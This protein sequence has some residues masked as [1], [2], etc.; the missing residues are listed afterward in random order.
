MR[1]HDYLDYHAR[2][3]PQ[4]D[5]AVDA[6]QR[7]TYGEARERANRLANALIAADLR[8]GDRI[9]FLSKN[10]AD[11][12]L[13]FLG[14]SKA[15]VVPVP[16][17]YRLAGPELAYIIG[18]AGARLLLA[19]A[20]Y[21]GLL[22]EIRPELITVERY[23]A[24]D[25]PEAAGWEDFRSMVASGSAAEPERWIDEES[26]VY[27]MYTSGTTGRPKGAILTHRAV[28]A[29]M[30]QIEAVFP[31]T[32]GERFLVVAPMYHAAAAATSFKALSAGAAMN[33]HADF[34]PDAVIDALSSQGITRVTLVPAMIQACLLTVPD[35]AARDYGSLKVITYGASPIAEQ[36]LRRAMEVFGCDFAQ[37]YGMTETTAVLTYLEP[38]DHRRALAE[39]PELLLSAGRPI[40]GTH[41]RIVDENEEEV[42]RGTIGEIVARGPQM[43]RGYWN[44]P[45]ASA[46]TL[47]DGWL[48]T[49]DAGV[50]DEEGFVYLQDRLKDMIVSGGENVYPREV[51]NVLFEHPAVADAAVLGV[52]DQKWGE[53]VKAVVVLRSGATATAEELVEFCR[54]R[55]AGYKRPRSV[56]FVETLPRNPSGKVLK[57]ELRE[58][59]WAGHSRRVS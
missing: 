32:R 29:Q 37:G 30:A 50:M 53:A 4:A 8:A 14:C 49:G 34:S 36:V 26:D 28:T 41:V 21:V 48:H 9:A 40:P 20:E 19:S 27:Q 44:L 57:R 47:K 46:E 10:S 6:H 5:F 13:V 2:R 25:A 39:K 59:Y 12:P 33:I 45:E 38:D 55:L 16:L 43:M 1:V 52:P 51:E 18:D 56:D 24:I 23:V 54:G 58:K 35:V 42:P 7:I 22:D 11:Y 15:G 17:N 3:R 31:M